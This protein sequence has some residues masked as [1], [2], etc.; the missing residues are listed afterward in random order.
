MN[1]SNQQNKGEIITLNRQRTQQQRPES[2]T[3]TPPGMPV[4]TR[5]INST[6]VHPLGECCNFRQ[7]SIF[8]SEV[9]NRHCKYWVLRQAVFYLHASG[10]NRRRQYINFW[11]WY[12]QNALQQKFRNANIESKCLDWH[13][14]TLT[15]V[16]HTVDDR[17]KILWG[18]F[19]QD[20]RQRLG[21]TIGETKCFA[22]H[23]CIL[24]CKVK[25]DEGSRY[26]IILLFDTRSSRGR[27]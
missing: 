24:K 22:D 6:E 19:I 27:Q 5:Y 15:V 16:L 11:R 25:I 14:F 9:F 12:R 7:S 13:C 26:K 1:V 20:G 8:I 4:K 2:R 10:L 3:V 17:V 21:Q 18:G 23:S